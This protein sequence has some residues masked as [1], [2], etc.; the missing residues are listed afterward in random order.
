M[1][2]RIYKAGIH[3]STRRKIERVIRQKFQDVHDYLQIRRE[4]MIARGELNPNLRPGGAKTIGGGA[5]G[6][7]GAGGIVRVKAHIRKGK[8]VRESTRHLGPVAKVAL[9]YYR[10][11]KAKTGL[12]PKGVLWPK[13][14]TSELITGYARTWQDVPSGNSLA[15][16][17]AHRDTRLMFHSLKVPKLRKRSYLR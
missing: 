7:L 12:R 16:R 6:K 10:D 3:P 9:N 2:K 14:R 1:A 4:G 5:T 17:L 11:Y 15:R 8:P 13:W